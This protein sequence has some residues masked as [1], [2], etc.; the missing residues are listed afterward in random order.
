LINM[1]DRIFWIRDGEIERIA[2]RGELTV[3]AG[4]IGGEDDE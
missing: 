4:S 1:A 3:E 2:L